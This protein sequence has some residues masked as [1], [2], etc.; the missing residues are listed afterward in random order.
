M[1][2]NE[3][4]TRGEGINGKYKSGVLGMKKGAQLERQREGEEE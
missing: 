4:R 2:S 3:E 1:E